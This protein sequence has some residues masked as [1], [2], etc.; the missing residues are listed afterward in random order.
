MAKRGFLDNLIEEFG[1]D[2]INENEKLIFDVTEM[3][4]HLMEDKNISKSNLAELLGVSVSNI[5]QML[6]GTKNM[7]LRTV[8]DILFHLDERMLIDHEPLYLESKVFDYF[9][10][11]PENEAYSVC[12]NTF[13]TPK[14]IDDAK[15]KQA[16]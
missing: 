8:S 13:C 15:H 9:A 16:A 6:N 3:I 12:Q 14:S 10:E 2:R 7:T 11:S 4:E 1:S 5:S